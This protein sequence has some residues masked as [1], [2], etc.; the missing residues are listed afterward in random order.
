[1]KIKIIQPGQNNEH[2]KDRML[3]NFI[4]AENY[5]PNF[6]ITSNNDYD[7]LV[8]CNEI[9]EAPIVPKNRIIGVIMEPY[10]NRGWDPNLDD[11]VGTIYVHDN[12]LFNYSKNKTVIIERPSLMFTEFYNSPDKIDDFLNTKF[13]KIEKINILISKANR[14]GANLYAKR[15]EFVQNII[16]SNLPINI[17]GRGWDPSG[18]LRGGFTKKLDVI[19]NAEFSISIENSAEK[20]YISEKFFDPLMVETVPIYFGCPNITEVYDKNS[21]IELPLDDF[22]ACLN[23]INN[24]LNLKIIRESYLEK[25]RKM[26]LKYLRANNLYTVVVNKIKELI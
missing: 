19:K 7:F 17:Y 10:W 26:R 18:V 20:N 6:E 3:K 4:W 13:E 14:P 5:D 15:I 16:N 8:V 21:F 24:I 22:D 12:S 25:I 11:K 2:M 1:M 23:L 9:S